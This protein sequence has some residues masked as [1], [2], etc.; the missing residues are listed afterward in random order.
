MTLN[1]LNF[2]IFCYKLS[3]DDIP[4]KTPCPWRVDGDSKGIQ[5]EGG[6]LTRKFSSPEGALLQTSHG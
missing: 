2:N 3:D 5:P 6:K 4:L 1:L